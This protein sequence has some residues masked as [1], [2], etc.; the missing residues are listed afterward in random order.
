MKTQD[1]FENM[2]DRYTIEDYRRLVMDIRYHDKL[3]HE[4][5]RP[6]ISDADYDSLRK[7]LNDIEEKHPEWVTPDSPSKKV[8]ASPSKKFKK[9][10]HARPML[11]LGN[12]FSD[13]EVYDF[14]ARLRRF[15]GMADD[16]DIDIW[17]E[18]KIDGLSC[19]IRYEDGK[20]VYAATRGD[21]YEGEDI[22]K[23]AMTLDDIPHILK[24]N[25]PKVVE[26]RG[27]IYIQKQDFLDMNARLI[28][29]GEEPFAN[30]RNAAAGSLRQLDPTITASRPLRFFAY[31]IG[32]LS[33]DI[34]KTQEGIRSVLETYGFKTPAPATC[35]HT[36]PDLLEYFQKLG[37][38]RAILAYDIDGAVYKVND[39]DLQE[40]L[41]FVARAPRWATAH[42]FPAQQAKT[43]IRDITVQVGRTGVLTPVA[44]LDPV[45]VGGVLVSRA[46]LHNEDEIT[47]KDFRIGDM[48]IIQ[49]A[50]DVIPQVV[51]VIEEERKADSVSYTMP[52]TCPACGSAAVRTEGEVYR[53]CTGGLVCP[54]QIVQRMIHFVSRNA[55]DI[56]GLGDKTVDEFY[57]AGFIKTPADIFTIPGRI[58]SHDIQLKDYDGWG[59]LSIQNLI[60]G[61]ED[62]RRIPINRFVFALGIPQI[63]EVMAQRL[64]AVYPAFNDWRALMK[65]AVEEP[66]TLIIDLTHIEGVGHSIAEDLVAFLS[67]PHNQKVMNDLSDQI[68]IEAYV[69]MKADVTALSGKTVVFTGT[70]VKMTRAE[71]KAKALACGAKVSSSVSS[72][73]DYVVAGEDAGSK[74]K[75]ARALEINV[76]TEDDFLSLCAVQF[77]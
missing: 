2:N 69:P 56:E 28:N 54:A 68:R 14:I 25:P 37:T 36:A 17:A 31:A 11:S 18:P 70:L 13:E 62:R 9:I 33:A 8:G 75:E 10:Q 38:D 71:A 34:A 3:Y 42:K 40:R 51:R 48:V 44:E 27:E 49:R 77:P 1:L 23:N 63:G 45:N 67:E 21:G 39:L 52:H 72:K 26:V 7:R 41:G 59:D 5:D 24:G 58:Q 74:L 66:E 12:V 76:I 6:E 53:R 60:A 57:R 50:G 29:Q 65:R 73:T 15:L 46:T 64:V 16:Q 19:S 20:L 4:Q 47:R 55:M 43:R 32:D 35:T 30:P 22:T 61:I